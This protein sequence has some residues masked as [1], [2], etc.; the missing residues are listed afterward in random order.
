MSLGE[1][2]TEL[3]VRI[4]SHL[5]GDSTALAALSET[6]KYYHTVAEPLLYDTIKIEWDVEFRIKQLL[7]TLLDKPR[8]ATYIRRV[9]IGPTRIREPTTRKDILQR[10]THNMFKGIKPKRLDD[11]PIEAIMPKFETYNL[12]VANAVEKVKIKSIS[13][14]G[15]KMSSGP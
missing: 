15:F 13:H 11:T 5:V 10:M 4:A 6:S 3:D 7:M 1:I 2:S 9:T 12:K 14:V 8:L